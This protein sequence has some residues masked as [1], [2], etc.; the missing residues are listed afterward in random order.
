MLVIVNALE[1]TEG[2]GTGVVGTGTGVGDTGA[3]TGTGTGTG[4]GFGLQTP[5]VSILEA[6][7][8]LVILI[9]PCD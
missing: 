7:P 5:A 1:L 4:V 3:G 6:V 2:A 9:I 8:K